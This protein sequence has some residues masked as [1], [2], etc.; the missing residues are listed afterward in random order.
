MY[1]FQEGWPHVRRAVL[2]KLAVKVP[3][4]LSGLLDTFLIEAFILPNSRTP[5]IKQLPVCTPITP[6]IVRTIPVLTEA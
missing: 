1:L 5:E 6:A 3:E 2:D 4:P